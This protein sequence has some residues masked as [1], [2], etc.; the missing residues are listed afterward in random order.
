MKFSLSQVAIQLQVKREAL[1]KLE[2]AIPQLMHCRMLPSEERYD[3]S[4]L[5]LLQEKLIDVYSQGLTLGQYLRQTQPQLAATSAQAVQQEDARQ[6]Q[7]S[8]NHT[9]TRAADPQ[10]ESNLSH[11][12]DE[13]TFQPDYEAADI[14]R[15][16]AHDDSDAKQARLPIFATQQQSIPAPHVDRTHLA[17]SRVQ[18][19]VSGHKAPHTGAESS[20]KDA[21]AAKSSYNRQP[22][23]QQ[24]AA[25][26]MEVSLPAPIERKLAQLETMVE[27]HPIPIDVFTRLSAILKNT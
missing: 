11:R 3:E 9:N 2:Q 20:Q 12:G 7:P 25:A 5:Q 19:S 27:K 18:S 16:G 8:N 13:L 22:N 10:Q 15:V 23:Q 17:A 4:D 6:P 14:P 21:K 1:L 24:T 26:G